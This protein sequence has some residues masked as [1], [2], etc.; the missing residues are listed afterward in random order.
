M[1]NDYIVF[2]NHRGIKNRGVISSKYEGISEDEKVTM[3][4][5]QW[6]LFH[7]QLLLSLCIYTG[8]WSTTIKYSRKE[9][10]V[11]LL[12]SKVIIDK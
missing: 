10:I 8:W 2:R 7:P 11:Y 9:V 3:I 1:T 6:C 12:Q 5:I 4:S